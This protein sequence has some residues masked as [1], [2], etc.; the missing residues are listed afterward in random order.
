MAGL[1]PVKVWRLEKQ[2]S[3]LFFSQSVQSGTEGVALGRQADSMRSRRSSPVTRT[4]KRQV[5]TE[6]CRFQ[7]NPP[8][9]VGEIVF[10]D[11]IQLRWMKF[12]STASGW[13]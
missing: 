2:Y 7:L 3:V 12:A 1:E 4:R 11:E 8:L 13:I 10:D 6:T 5:S 9:R